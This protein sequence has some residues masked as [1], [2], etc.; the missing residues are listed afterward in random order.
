MSARQIVS[1]TVVGVVILFAG[2]L[3]WVQ[4]GNFGET[5]ISAVSQMNH[6]VDWL[7]RAVL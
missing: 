6:P 2:F 4:F 1:V 7:C 3:A 5:Y